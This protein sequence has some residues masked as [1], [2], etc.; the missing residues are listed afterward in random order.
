MGSALSVIA[1]VLLFLLI[2]RLAG[3][4]VSR[5][6]ALGTRLGI[7]TFFLG[8]LLGLF[9]SA[10]EAAIAINAA[11]AQAPSLSAGNLIGGTAVLFGLIAALLAI[12]A[13]KLPVHEG[14]SGL[15]AAGAYLLLPVI[16]AL[17]GSLSLVDAL[18]LGAGYFG[19]LVLVYGA[20]RRQGFALP[21][22]RLTDGSPRDILVLIAATAAIALCAAAVVRLTVPLAAA[23][24]I[25]ELVIGIVA[26]S[27]GTNLPELM[28]AARASKR[29]DALPV[30]TLLGSALANPFMLGL[31][32]LSADRPLEFHDGFRAVAALYAAIVALFFVFARSGRRFHRGEGIA[33]FALYVAFVLFASRVS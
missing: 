28:I 29:P 23:F 15:A 33:L 26:Y 14:I 4:V 18:A 9:T 24:G 8:V 2:G 19:V 11:A 21:H 16:L 27:L 22:V 12:R 32:A 13:G 17:D 20:S 5:A 1:I 25:P 6:R 31:L 10:P 7:G 3:V 30:A